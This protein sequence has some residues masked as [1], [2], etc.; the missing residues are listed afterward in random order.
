MTLARLTVVASAVLAVLGINSVILGPAQELLRAKL[1]V[2]IGDLSILFV[3]LSFGYLISSPLLGVL[4]RRVSQRTLLAS[5]VLLVAAMITIALGDS[6]SVLAIAAF[7]LGLGQALTQVTYLAWIGARLRGARGASSLL[8]RVNAFYGVGAL[9]GPILVL[10]GVALGVPLL[11]F[12]LAAALSSLVLMIGL[13]APLDATEDQAAPLSDEAEPSRLLRSPALLGMLLTMALYVG[14]EVAFS[15]Y[16]TLYVSLAFGAPIQTAAF[17]TSLFFGGFAFSRYFAG[18][19]LDRVDDVRAILVL[20][21]VAG[22]GFAVMLLVTTP[23]LALIGSAIVGIGF[24]PIYPTMLSI[25]IK[26]FPKSPRIVSSLVTSAG[27]VGSV[28]LPYIVGQTIDVPGAGPWLALGEQMGVI[29]V[30]V[31]VWRVMMRRIHD[32]RKDS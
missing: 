23:Q 26:A 27:S 16:S 29:G 28:T 20:L 3:A 8:N 25:A 6:V 10:L 2:S 30:A 9:I 22:I 18:V 15:A 21:F 5:P 19:L 11:V 1:G 24:G 7:I 17:A 32:A 13:T 14:C 12:W 31:L 4:A